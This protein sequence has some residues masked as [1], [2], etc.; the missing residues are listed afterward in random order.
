MIYFFKR[1]III[2]GV[3]LA[4]PAVADTYRYMHVTIDT[5]WAIFI[6]LMFAILLPFVLM[7]VLYWKNAVRRNAEADA[8]EI[9]SHQDSGS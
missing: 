4:T 5:P 2:F 6:G 8:K 9:E 1:L 7:A 3:G